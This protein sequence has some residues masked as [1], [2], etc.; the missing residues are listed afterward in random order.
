MRP[1][2]LEVI[3]LAAAEALDHVLV[4]GSTVEMAFLTAMLAEVAELEVQAATLP[5]VVLVELREL[6]RQ[7]YQ[8]VLWRSQQGPCQLRFSPEL[9]AIL[10]AAAHKAVPELLLT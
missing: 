2:A 10:I 7:L 1:V 9:L 6:R 5:V 8:P 4:T 3:P